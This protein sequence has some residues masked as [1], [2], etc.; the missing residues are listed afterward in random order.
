MPSSAPTTTSA[1]APPRLFA[2]LEIATGK[3]TGLCKKQHR[4][5]EF[6]AFLKHVARAYPDVELHLVMDNYTTHKHA[7][8]KAWL[9][10]NPRI[11]VHFTPTSG[12]WLNMV[13]VWFGIIERQAIHRGSF[14]TGARP[15]DQDPRVHHRLEPPQAPLHLDQARRR[16]PRQDRPQT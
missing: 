16:D 3:V 5:Q 9:A 2:A 6:L 7:K 14:P 12:S 11:H 4:H 10:A 8:V 13:E 1:T 15:H